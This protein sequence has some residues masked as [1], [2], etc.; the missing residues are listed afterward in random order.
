MEKSSHVRTILVAVSDLRYMSVTINTSYKEMSRWVE[1]TASTNT[2]MTRESSY[3]YGNR[4][5]SL[6]NFSISKWLFE[7]VQVL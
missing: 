6:I 3:N 7:G 2:A 5:L 4:K 1:N